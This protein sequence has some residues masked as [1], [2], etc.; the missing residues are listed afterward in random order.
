[1]QRGIATFTLDSGKCPKW[2]FERMVSL[3]REMAEVLIQE[4]GPDEFIKRIGDPVW[5]QSL[6]TVLAFDWNASGLTTI[7][8]AALKEAIRGRE[9]ELGIFIC[10]G[11]GKTSLKTPDEI[12]KWGQILYLPA[13]YTNKLVY[14]SKM[15]AKV[16]SSLIQDGFQ[17]YHHA[18]FFSKNGAWTVIQQGMNQTKQTARRYHWHSANVK[19]I[20]VEP[21]TG[22]VCDLVHK[23]PTLN[24]TSTKSEASRNISV[25]MVQN[26]PRSFLKDMEILRKH[27]TKL[28]QVLS[29]GADGEQLTFM[30]LEPVEFH[31][32]DVLTEDFSQSKYLERILLKLNSDKPKSYE[33]LLATKGV[34]PKTIRALSLV[35]EVIYGAK[36]S[37]ED[38]ARYSFAHGGK[39]ATPYP[40]DRKTYDQTIEIIKNVVQ[41]SKIEA[42]EKNKAVKRL[43]NM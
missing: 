15:S 20:I 7:L 29:M 23:S 38:P 25:E 13:E 26:N 8:T 2:L 36:A 31:T 30:K 5:F 28:S 43:M 33:Q 11:K 19:D 39:D 3:G 16:D 10:G 37:Y 12:E 27:S 41:K 42:S 22:I 1:M 40:V 4:Y 21:H 17:L 18:F 14:N 6:G 34:G 35:G 32:H 9:K 24:M